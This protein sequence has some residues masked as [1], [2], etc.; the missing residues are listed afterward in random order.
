VK[1]PYAYAS[2]VRPDYLQENVEPVRVDAGDDIPTI[3]RKLLEAMLDANERN[4]QT[5][6][7]RRPAP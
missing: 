6:A 3:V 1:D 4:R 2:I 5:S 7:R